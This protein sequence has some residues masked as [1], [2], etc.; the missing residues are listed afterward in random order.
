MFVSKHQK[1]IH[2]NKMS[3]Q[4]AENIAKT[5]TKAFLHYVFIWTMGSFNVDNPLESYNNKSPVW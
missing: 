5:A 4:T 1:I 2:L 3:L